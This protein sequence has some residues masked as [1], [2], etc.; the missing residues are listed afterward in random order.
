MFSTPSLSK[1]IVVQPEWIYQTIVGRLLSKPPLPPPHV[2]YDDNGCA[3]LTEVERILSTDGIPG[4]F[5][6]DMAHERGLLIKRPQFG[7]VVVPAKLLAT[8]PSHVWQAFLE[9]LSSGFIPAGRRLVCTGSAGISSAFFPLLQAFLHGIFK[10]EHNI[11]IPLWNGGLFVALSTKGAAQ[12]FIQ[13]TPEVRSI[14][15]VVQ[16]S[17]EN[18]DSSSDLLHLLV[19]KVLHL[20]DKLSPGSGLK[21]MFLSSQQLAKLPSESCTD[22]WS[23]R[24]YSLQSVHT[25]L[26]SGGYVSNGESC[27]ESLDRMLLSAEEAQG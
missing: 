18:R 22:T 5:T 11:E 16:G 1:Y 13:A 6:V 27:P 26:M 24:A 2:V 15:V 20:A 3:P 19:E 9:A 4:K 7:D 17:E 23:C 25:A 8:R 12:A 14:D 10:E 21:K